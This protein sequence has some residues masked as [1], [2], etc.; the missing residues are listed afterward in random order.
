MFCTSGGLYGALVL[1]RLL[2]SRALSVVGVVIST[3]I[4]RANEGWLPGVVRLVGLTGLR[5]A[6]YLG[7]ATGVA[8]FLGRAGRLP[9]VSRMAEAMRIPVFRT[10]DLNASAG[11][12]FI[13]GQ[14]P[15]LL[16]SAFFN[17]RIG[18][19][20]C[21]IPQLGAVNI[22]PSLL[23]DFKGVDPVFHARLNGVDRLGVSLHRIRPTFDTGELLAQATIELDARDSLLAMTARLFDHGGCLLLETLPEILR[24]DTGTPQPPGGS[25]DSWPSAEQVKQFRSGGGRLA[26]WGDMTLMR[27]GPPWETAADCDR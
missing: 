14:A 20:I 8:E 22:H 12:A 16:V 5:Y 9:P 6:L 11:Q 25:Y 27:S 26:D 23:P 4:L 21:A 1:R 13:A 10:V 15:D 18:E 7:Y 17:Q 19:A 3:R 24:G 2:A